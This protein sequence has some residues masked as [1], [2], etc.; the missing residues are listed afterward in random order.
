MEFVRRKEISKTQFPGRV[1]QTAVGKGAKIESTKMMVGF[2]HYSAESG[3]MEPHRHIEESIL[4]L[5][6]QNASFRYGPGTD[7][8]GDPVPIES[9]MV[10]HFNPLEWH[11]FE[12]SK[13]GYLDIFFVYAQV[14]NIYPE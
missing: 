3:P 9:G 11:V 12:Y 10:L 7:K 13:G 6:A 4:V 5:D 2:G 8:L 14:E 1:V